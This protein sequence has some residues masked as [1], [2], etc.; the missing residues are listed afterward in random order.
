MRLG[1]YWLGCLIRTVADGEGGG[2][3]WVQM[4]CSLN[5]FYRLPIV[6]F[7]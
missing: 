6:G 3:A 5:S 4:S 2:I 1:V 7:I